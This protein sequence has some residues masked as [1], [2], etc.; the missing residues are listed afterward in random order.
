MSQY[1]D[2]INQI[3][4]DFAFIEGLETASALEARGGML[5]V[6]YNHGGK[7]IEFN[8][9][10][11]YEGTPGKEGDIVIIPPT[12]PYYIKLKAMYSSETWGHTIAKWWKKIKKI[13]VPKNV[14]HD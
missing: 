13:E 6:H 3:A 10:S 12:D 2:K 9:D 4:E 7:R 11:E 8:R 14:F 5:I 1:T